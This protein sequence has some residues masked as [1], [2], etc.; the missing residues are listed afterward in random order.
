MKQNTTKYV[1]EMM[2]WSKMF[3]LSVM[4]LSEIIVRLFPLV[5]KL[6]YSEK[7]LT[8]PWL[9]MPRVLTLLGHL[10]CIHDIDHAEITQGWS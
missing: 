6:E 7:T 8:M 2:F 3:L 10:I 5:V 1:Y 4:E 9:L